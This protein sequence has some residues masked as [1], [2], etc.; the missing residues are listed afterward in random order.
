MKH[1]DSWYDISMREL[2][3]AIILEDDPLFVPF[4]KEKLNRLIYSAIRTGALQFKKVCFN[5]SSARISNDEWIH[6]EPMFVIGACLN[7]RD[8]RFFQK[9]RR[10]AQPVLTTHKESST[11]CAHAYLLTA[12]TARLLI[13]QIPLHYVEA[14]TPDILLNFLVNAS[15]ILQ[16]F[17]VDPPLVYQGNRVDKDLDQI[18]TF[19][20]TKYNLPL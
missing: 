12:C 7:Y 13:E 17:W 1:L 9:H 19:K 4:F 11:R 20:E 10:D 2:P 8:S 3:L 5:R 16:S 18:P 15:S 14:D 6:Q